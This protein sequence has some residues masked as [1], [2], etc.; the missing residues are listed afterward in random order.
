MES[1]INA[2]A[3]DFAKFGRL[4]LR[5]GDWGGKQ[6]IPARWVEESTGEDTS[7][8]AQPTT[9]RRVLR[10]SARAIL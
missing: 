8:T 2:R 1:G 3:I 9:P 10:R 4:F 7:L 6:V 5:K